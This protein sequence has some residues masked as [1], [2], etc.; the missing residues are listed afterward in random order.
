MSSRVSER[1]K[2]TKLGPQKKLKTYLKS[3]V[4]LNKEV[5]NIASIKEVTVS[6]A[7]QKFI[8]VNKTKNIIHN[9]INK[10]GSTSMMGEI[11]KIIWP[12]VFI[13]LLVGS[14]VRGVVSEEQLLH[15]GP[16]PALAQ[17]FLP[18]SEESSGPAAV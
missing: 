12:L 17:I 7:E 9:R 1:S 15:G 5:D 13:R 18:R 10:A 14:P 3:H 11:F 2:L 8:S 6:K 16:W 4:K